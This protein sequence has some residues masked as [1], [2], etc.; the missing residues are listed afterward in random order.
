[1]SISWRH[2]IRDSAR[3][4]TR[5]VFWFIVIVFALIA[6]PHYAE[7]IRQPA[8]LVDILS[9]LNLSRHGFERIL[10][11]VPIVWSGFMFGLRGAVVTCFAALAVMLPRALFISEYPRDALFE[12]GAVFI[13]G[14]ILAVTIGL[15]RRERERRIQLESAQQEFQT[16][17]EKYR[18]IF[19]NAN[20][21]IWL[22]DMDGNIIAANDAAAKLIGYS[23]E[24]L[25]HM[26][27]KSL[28]SKESRKSAREI[29]E[30][31]LKG[32]YVEQPYEQNVI[33]KQGAHTFFK[34]T[35]NVVRIAGQP[36]GFQL[37]ARDV[38]QERRIR[39]NLDFYLQHSAWSHE[40]EKKRV[41]SRLYDETCQELFVLSRQIE[42]LSEDG[43]KALSDNEELC[44]KIQEQIRNIMSNVRRLSHDLRPPILDHLGLLPAIQSLVTD[45]E[46]YSSV[47]TNLNI[48]GEP[49]RLPGHVEVVLFRVT[50]EALRNVHLH[51]N[52]KNAEVNVEFDDGKTVVSIIDNGKG[53]DIP[54][55]VGDLARTGKLGLTSIQE[56]TRFVGGKLEIRSR[57]GKGTKIAVEV[58]S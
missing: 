34:L 41:S 55:M 11:L 6:I 36:A 51:S 57:P 18:Q 24:E 39:E 19:E 30:K 5:P 27:V 37:I 22:H 23:R 45:C 4:V 3:E 14:N 32:E 58:P 47:A 7:A 54:E 33:T 13:M 28:L 12:T 29:R 17:E 21:A 15:M 8:F 56:Q 52:A 49:R 25:S 2:L 44:T 35:T 46:A 50:Q 20:D 38:T 48:K 1:M 16:S 31:L 26:N 40:D 10:F 9:Y 42:N 53:S 43:Y